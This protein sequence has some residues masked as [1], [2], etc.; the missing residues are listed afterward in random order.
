MADLGTLEGGS[1]S[2]ANGIN[3]L[4]QVVGYSHTGSSIHAAM[5]TVPLPV[6]TPEDA[7]EDATEAVEAL[8]A[9]GT[10]SGG[11]ANALLSKLEAAQLQ[12][13][14]GRANA[15]SNVLRA[16]IHQLDAFVRSGRL[17]AEEAQPLKDSATR[18]I[19]LIGAQP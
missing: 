14:W 7:I 17:S 1:Y 18:I 16:F 3:N 2:R 12:L 8:V 11:E 13:A 9:D 15:A 19:E 5:W 4:G 10:L 6:V